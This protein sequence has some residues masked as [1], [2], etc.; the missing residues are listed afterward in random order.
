[1]MKQLYYLVIGLIFNLNAVAANHSEGIVRDSVN[2]GPY[3]FKKNNEL[4][5][6]WIE[7][8]AF[9]EEVIT[10]A[11]FNEIKN[12][13]N[14]LFNYNHLY[15][16]AYLKPKFKQSYSKVDSIVIISDLHGEFG[17]YIKL[18]KINGIIDN[19]LS[20]NFGK[21]HLVVLGDIF[22]R[23]D[24]VTE[25][26]WHLFGLEKQAAKAGGKVHILLG[27]HELLVLERDIGYISD[28]Y[29]KVAAITRTNYFDLYSDSTILGK[30]LR[31]KPVM[32]TINDIIFV[33]AGISMEMLKK[34]LNVSQVNRKFTKTIYGV[35][36][37]MAYPDEDL[38]F[39]N[40]DEGPIW[41]RGYFTD[42]DFCES[43]IDSILNFYGKKHIVVGHTPN[44]GVRSLFNNKILGSDSGISYKRPGEI[45]LY[46]NGSFY[47]SCSVGIRVKL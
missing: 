23:G 28:K 4:I 36:M 32:I 38:D 17:T 19:T 20:W 25:I 37:N 29:K 9:R 18:L 43:K 3:I 7:N 12:E 15:N 27:N 2:D 35:D 46:K 1:M 33:H 40:E 42:S 39:L 45:L 13:F 44:N 8:N 47:K 41:Y 26:F 31:S 34:E 16:A 30:W 10:S 5:A 14:L 22:D 21:G 6:W 11:N 24:M